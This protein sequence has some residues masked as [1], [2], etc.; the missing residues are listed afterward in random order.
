MQVSPLPVTTTQ[1]SVPWL[2]PMQMITKKCV[3]L[4]LPSISLRKVSTSASDNEG[5]V[6]NTRTVSPQELVAS[7]A[8]QGSWEEVRGC[9]RPGSGA[10]NW[11]WLCWYWRISVRCDSRQERMRICSRSSIRG[12]WSGPKI[13]NRNTA[14]QYKHAKMSVTVYVTFYGKIRVVWVLIP[15]VRGKS[16]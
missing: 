6:S 14:V 5:A 8:S 11:A 16:I 4:S 9:A 10:G 13:R 1:D 12:I 3:W 7:L 15:S 2:L